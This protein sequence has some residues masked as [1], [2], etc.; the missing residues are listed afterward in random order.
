MTKPSICLEVVLMRCAS[1]LERCRK[2]FCNSTLSM[3]SS[4][5]ACFS[6]VNF[7]H[8][9]NEMF[10]LNKRMINYVARFLASICFAVGIEKLLAKF[11]LGILYVWVRNKLSM[12]VKNALSAHVSLC[13]TLLSTVCVC[14]CNVFYL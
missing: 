4:R 14:I 1:E 11:V 2:L 10:F 8:E 7:L 9:L 13:Q 3:M 6:S 5:G 12:L